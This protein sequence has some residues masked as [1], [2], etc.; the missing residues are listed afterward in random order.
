VACCR[1]RE[2]PAATYRGEPNTRTTPY[3]PAPYGVVVASGKPRGIT[4]VSLVVADYDEA[5]DFYVESLG[6]ELIE[7]TA[8]SP[9]K[10]WVVVA[11]PS[12]TGAALLLAKAAS[13][14]Q[15]TRIGDQTGGRVAFF[16]V[17]DDFR[18]DHDRMARAGV[19]FLEEPREEGYGSVVQFADLYGNKWDLLE[20]RNP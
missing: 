4:L 6:F 19:R 9:T 5:R 8:L 7:D 20:R 10:R 3:D 13:P 16:L 1:D 17:T 18:R 15:R 14:E 11:P 12:G 2:A